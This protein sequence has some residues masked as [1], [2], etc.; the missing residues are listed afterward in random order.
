MCVLPCAVAQVYLVNCL[1]ACHSVLVVRPVAGAWAQR[2]ADTINRYGCVDT[3]IEQC[4][5]P[6]K[7]SDRLT[8][9][10]CVWVVCWDGQQ[11][12]SCVSCMWDVAS[13]MVCSV[14]GGRILE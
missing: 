4:A 6:C 13:C 2:L 8:E 3:V 5:K 12:L 9:G 11:G 10:W 14:S 1:A 7:V